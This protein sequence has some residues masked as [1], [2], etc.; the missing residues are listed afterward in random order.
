MGIPNETML[1]Y[2][3]S[4]LILLLQ[5]QLKTHG[6]LP[7]KVAV[8]NPTQPNRFLLSSFEMME[9]KNLMRSNKASQKFLI[10]RGM[11]P[12]AVRTS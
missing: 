6:D 12:T 5:Q 9:A 2:N 1:P 10:L 11:A 8:L 3:I 4:E 7:V